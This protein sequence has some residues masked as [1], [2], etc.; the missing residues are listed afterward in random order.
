MHAQSLNRSDNLASITPIAKPLSSRDAALET[1]RLHNQELR[2]R[3]DELNEKIQLE[4]YFQAE[5]DNKI[6]TLCRQLSDTQE[7]LK[8]LR[9]ERGKIQSALSDSKLTQ[10]KLRHANQ[11]AV[12]EKLAFKEQI[13]NLQAMIDQLVQDNQRK[14]YLNNAWTRLQSEVNRFNYDLGEL[15]T[16]GRFRLQTWL[17]KHGRI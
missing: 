16:I 14:N 6:D 3:N 9:A 17:R 4:S 11:V 1:L 8:Q 13:Q 12:R 2:R 10:I 7:E 5:R 15:A